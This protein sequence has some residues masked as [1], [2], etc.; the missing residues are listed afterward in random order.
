MEE[1]SPTTAHL[2]CPL[3]RPFTE[4]P[5]EEKLVSPE[6]FPCQLFRRSAARVL[7]AALDGGLRSLRQDSERQ[8]K[9]IHL[10][11]DASSGNAGLFEMGVAR[12]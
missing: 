1:V 7:E 6:Y 3:G 12:C 8:L 10:L 4:Y 11:A 2:Q 9:H 5:C